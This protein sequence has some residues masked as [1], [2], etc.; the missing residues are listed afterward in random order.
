M[1]TD[2]FTAYATLKMQAAQVDTQLKALM[3][4][5]A[6]ELEATG[7]KHE[8]PFGKFSTK[9]TSKWTYSAKVQE[10]EEQV[11]VLKEKEK[12]AGT[13]TAETS[14]SVVFTLAKI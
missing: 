4:E 6:K 12:S 9:T 11:D 7:G 1:T 3:P 5:I 14:T 13:A 8:T 2:I 10:L